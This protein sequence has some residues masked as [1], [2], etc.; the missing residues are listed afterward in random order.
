MIGLRCKDGVVLGAEKIIRSK[1]LVKSSNRRVHAAA[2]THEEQAATRLAVP[3]RP[4][5]FLVV[6][7]HRL[8]EGE[9]DDVPASQHRLR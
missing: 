4:A 1:L 9:V 8:G 5:R 2:C 7:L 6:A 3:P